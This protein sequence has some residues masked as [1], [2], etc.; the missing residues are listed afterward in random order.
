MET[1]GWS[2]G[3]KLAS[4]C[5]GPCPQSSLV[6]FMS[7]VAAADADGADLLAARSA[8][9]AILLIS[10]HLLQMPSAADHSTSS[11]MWPAVM[12]SGP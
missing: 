7:K 11:L 8:A 6:H 9:Y 10:V 4:S 12:K 1:C 5:T 2:Q 3:A